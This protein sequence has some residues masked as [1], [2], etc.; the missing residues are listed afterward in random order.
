MLID[1]G[2]GPMACVLQ[3]GAAGVEVGS[4][5]LRTGLR[6]SGT[7]AVL[8]DSALVGNGD[9]VG[10]EASVAAALQHRLLT[11][12]ARACGV[13]RASVDAAAA[14]LKERRQFG[15]RLA[16]MPG[17]R[18]MAAAAAVRLA[19]AE[20]AMWSVAG[21]PDALR[22]AGLGACAETAAMCVETAVQASTDALQ[23]HGGYGYTR[24]FPV[25]RL[26]RDALSLRASLGG[27]GAMLE[28]AATALMGPAQEYQTKS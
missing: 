9:V 6:G 3:A 25:E 23:L 28:I 7:R 27:T 13:A 12:A 2:S 1:S 24:D 14:Y 5:D 18:A 11:T 21:R 16:D 17:L 26:L 19:A 8:L 22:P 15:V 10:G 20:A 4:A